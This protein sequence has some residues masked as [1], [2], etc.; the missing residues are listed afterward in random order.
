MSTLFAPAQDV[1]QGAHSPRRLPRIILVICGLWLLSGVYLVQPDQQAVVTR[2]GGVSAPRVTPGLHYALPWPIDRVYKLKV[3]QTRRLAIGGDLSDGVL[4]RTQPNASQ[5]ITGDQNIIN[6][7][8]VV[9]YSVGDPARFLF[10]SQD[11]PALIGAVVESELARRIGHTRVDDV[12]TTEKV[13]IQNGVR[14]SAQAGLD[15]YQT[16]VILASVNIDSVTPPAEA[17]DAFR[18]V[19]SARADA[20]RT[21]SESQG[22]SNDL[23]PRARGEATQM[24]ESAQAYKESKVNIAEGDAS[25]FTQIA[26]EYAKAAKVTSDRTYIEAME[27]ILPRIKKMILDPNDKLDLTIVRRGDSA[28]TKK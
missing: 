17:A 27:Q 25:R 8:V 19:A 24:L 3:Q 12:L 26:A 21:V 6:M 7:N 16:G 13:A 18:D 4:G 5:F 20:I 9:Q 15:E 1:A 14:R 2:F 11:V 22:Y 10:H 28:A 23:L